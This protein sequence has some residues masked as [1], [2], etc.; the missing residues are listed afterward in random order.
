MLDEP[1][2]GRRGLREDV[3]AGLEISRVQERLDQAKLTWGLGWARFGH[4]E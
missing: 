1:G 3:S 2:L 4:A